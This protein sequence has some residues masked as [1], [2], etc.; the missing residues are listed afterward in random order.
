MVP[1]RLTDSLLPN[2]QPSMAHALARR[3]TGLGNS[4]RRNTFESPDEIR[5]PIGL[6]LQFEPREPLIEFIFVHGF[7]GGSRRTWSSSDDVATFW[8]REWLPQEEGFSRVRIHT[9][10]Y[11]VDCPDRKADV[12]KINHY[13]KLLLDSINS[14]ACFRKN[15]PV[16]KNQPTSKNFTDKSCQNPIVFI[17]HSLGGLVVKKVRLA[18]LN[19][20]PLI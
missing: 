9:F 7:P 2:S 20:L 18:M 12:G 14:N 19:L 17:A 8:P 3:V 13:G 11:D 6:R 4:Q 15:D 1:R 5:G 16:R 10:G